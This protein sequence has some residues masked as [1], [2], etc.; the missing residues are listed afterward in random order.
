MNKHNIILAILFLVFGFGSGFF[1]FTNFSNV[2]AV[3]ENQEVKNDTVAVGQNK[4]FALFDSFKNTP[5]HSNIIKIREDLGLLILSYP[6]GEIVID[7]D[8]GVDAYAVYDYK[9]DVMY[10]KV[11]ST[12]L[13]MSN[14]PIAIVNKDTILLDNY[15]DNTG[16]ASLT[17]KNIKNG[18]T[19]V[20]S[21]KRNNNERVSANL[22]P[23]DQINI[24]VYGKTTLYYNL[25]PQ[26]LELKQVWE[27]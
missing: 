18:T 7:G 21:I 22:N 6:E 2:N 4:L 12:S 27:R 8:G 9:N 14:L 16:K 19:K 23:Q 1:Y 20:L 15:D 5:D 25:N 11:G 26:T 13:G 3:V 10:D 17:L 24:F